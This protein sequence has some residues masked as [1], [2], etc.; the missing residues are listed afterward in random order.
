MKNILFNFDYSNKVGFGNFYRCSSLAR[1][2]KKKNCKTILLTSSKNYPFLKSN[3]FFDKIIQ[4]NNNT[5]KIIKYYEKFKCDFLI[6]DKI[7]KK[8]IL[9]KNNKINW[10]EFVPNI[11]TRSFADIVL[12]TIPYKSNE[13]FIKIYNDQKIYF[14]EKYSILRDQ[15]YKKKKFKTKDYIFICLGGG[16]DK[17]LTLKII[18]KIYSNLNKYKIYLL[19]GQND[20]LYK[21]KNWIA[22]NDQQKKII[23]I[24]KKNHIVDYIDQSRFAICSAGI[25]SHEINSR[26]KKMILVSIVDNQLLQAR[27]WMNYGHEYIGH[28]NNINFSKLESLVEKF[29]EIRLTEKFKVKEKKYLSII[30]EI[31]KR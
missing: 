10:L 23:L 27:K 30:N 1:E 2:F 14:G 29:K 19:I 7:S 8:K 16:N 11:N 3:F 5:K 12:C 13:K 15:F 18:K 21:I 20:N 28:N 17:G 31:I 24:T 22:I 9:F 4:I 26:L 25:I 6:Y